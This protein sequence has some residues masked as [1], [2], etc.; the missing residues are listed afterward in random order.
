VQESSDS[1]ANRLQSELGKSG[2]L[3]SDE[4]ARR[5]AQTSFDAQAK[6][7]EVRA[8]EADVDRAV[9]AF[10]PRLTLT[11]RYTRLSDVEQSSVGPESGSLVGTTAPAGPLPPGA[12]LFGIPANSFS[13]PQVLN[14]YLLQANLTVPLSDYVLS[15][16]KAY[17]A[18]KT[19]KKAAELNVRASRLQAAADARVAYYSWVR[20]KLSAVVADDSVKQAKAQLTS[21]ELAVGAGR[22]SDA[23]RLRAQSGVANAELLALRADGLVRVTE[24]R[25]R[26][27]M[28]D[29]RPQ[30]YQI[31]ERVLVEKPGDDERASLQT[32]IQQALSRR[33]EL[34][35]LSQSSASLSKQSEV[36][37]TTAAPRL[38]AFGNVYYA[39]PNP[40]VFPQEERWDT[41][42]DVGVQLTWS[43]NDLGTGSAQARGLSAQAAQLKLQRKA[44]EDAVRVE[45]TQAKIALAEAR[46]AI[47][48]SER[49]LVAA[50][51]AYKVR[52]Q[53][54]EF[55]R[56]T[57]VE[58]FDAEVELLRARLG[59]IDAYIGLRVA[60]VQLDHAVGR[61]VKP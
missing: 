28:H 13:F 15:T 7:A 47:N 51:S 61:D 43:P 10:V 26:V 16:S 1:I 39:N 55:G 32:L 27:A 29:E 22:A 8:A 6:L 19:S 54:Y 48:A 17:A 46:K 53:L 58:L 20:A 57:S 30:R 56:A 60:R 40:R 14:Q 36:I 49:A 38:E 42:W 52:R 35:A 31:G 3:T 34:Q 50:E 24:A 41:T 9:M 23:D 18:T 5:A 59:W 12:P 33:L 37:S 45:V 11:A 25:L 21:V 44:L 2:G 4:V